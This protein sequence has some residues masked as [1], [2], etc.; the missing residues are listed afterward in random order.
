MDVLQNGQPTPH[1]PLNFDDLFTAIGAERFFAEIW[2]KQP[3]ILKLRKDNF[4]RICDL[5]GPLEIGRLAGL[6]RDGA[7]AWLSNDY[8]EHSVF[9]VDPATASQYFDIG[10][11]LY[12]LNIPIPALT[13][14]MADALGAP[15]DRLIASL[16]LT[17]ASGGA[18]PHFDKNENFTIQL[19]GRKS[20]TVADEPT[21]SNPHKGYFF[22]QAIPPALKLLGMDKAGR[23]PGRSYTLTPGT[24]LYVPRG[25][26]H[27]TQAEE[28]SWSLNISYTGLMWA[29]VLIDALYQHLLTRPV[30]RRSAIGL[31]ASSNPAARNQNIA[32]ALIADLS[33][34]LATGDLLE[35]LAT[36]L[37]GAK[38]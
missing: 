22:D 24:M 37:E 31:T 9:P 21:I 30:W 36:H 11:T 12:F 27:S 16:F 25:T 34:A 18:A 29:D 5:T 14:A 8:V 33:Q 28:Q 35:I 19:T 32:P 3:A 2:E 7:Q 13:D 38:S 1:A 23:P 17:P 4:A 26:A 20:W 15:R 10:A 6:A